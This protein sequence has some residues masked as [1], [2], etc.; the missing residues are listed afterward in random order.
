MSRI[1]CFHSHL[2]NKDRMWTHLFQ[3]LHL[4]SQETP[5]DDVDDSDHKERAKTEP[6]PHSSSSHWEWRAE[7]E[8]LPPE[9][10]DPG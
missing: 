5:D 2:K 7:C 1:G 10:D 9:A 4:I 6:V 3:C 8:M